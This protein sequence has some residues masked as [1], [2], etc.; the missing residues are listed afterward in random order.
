MHE[1]SLCQAIA[2][3]VEARAG[4]R[5]VRRVE[6]RI[7][8]LRQVVPD[9]LQ[10][11]WEMLTETSSLSDCELAVEHIAAVVRCRGCGTD[12]TLEWPILICAAC[13]GH[14]VDLRS[15]D[16]LELAWIDVAEEVG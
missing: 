9:S 1:L 11:A 4:G 15:G 10:F 8:H 5:P 16:E 2:D 12:T 13:E 3:H 7:G 6:V 14:D